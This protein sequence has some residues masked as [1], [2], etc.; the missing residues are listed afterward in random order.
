MNASSFDLV[1]F[2]GAFHPL[3]VHLPIGFLILLL[4]LEF[5]SWLPR[6]ENLVAANR[7]ILV[8]TIP[9]TIAAA[10]CGWLLA[11]EGGYEPGL[12]TWHRWSGVALAAAIPLAW[13]LHL[14]ESMVAYR[15]VLIAAAVLLGATGHFGGS[16]TH[17]RDFLARHAPP[18]LKPLLGG[19]RT[20]TPPPVVTT[21]AA[22]PGG[23]VVYE[24]VI[25]PW[26]EEYCTACHGPEKVKGELR[27]DSVDAMLKGGDSGPALVA[28]N[29]ADSLLIQRMHL[30]L[31]DDD[32]MPPDGK[33]QPTADEI[34]LVAWWIDAG[35][36]AGRSA[37]D[38]GAPDAI[39]QLL[40]A[41]QATPET[42][43][44]APSP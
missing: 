4:T 42:A 43:P 39:L 11:E 25:H 22:G 27:L 16:L 29:S 12:L 1:R 8:L 24:S 36:A 21:T 18:A 20:E 34:A 3:V 38:L 32:H 40:S 15:L 5:L 6:F 19:K 13:V 37:T 44:P 41:Q 10:A 30:P 2:L 14:R 26:M 33:N 9:A 35:A 31:D 28:G 17:G 7:I 23:V